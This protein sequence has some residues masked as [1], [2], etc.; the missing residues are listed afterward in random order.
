VLLL[1]RAAAAARPNSTDLD[2][3]AAEASTSTSTGTASIP[4]KVYDESLA[5]VFD[6]LPGCHTAPNPLDNSL[7]EWMAVKEFG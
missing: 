2:I 6:R 7:P 4:T 1:T 5:S 3:D